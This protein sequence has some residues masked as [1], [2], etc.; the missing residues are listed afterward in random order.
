[1]ETL[2]FV[3]LMS[4]PVLWLGILLIPKSYVSH[5]SLLIGRA[6]LAGTWLTISGAVV[7]A[8]MWISSGPTVLPGDGITI[9]FLDGLSV[10]MSLLIGFIGWVIVRFSQTYLAGEK[11]YGA[12]FQWMGG[13]LASVSVLVISGN[14]LVLLAAWIA[15]SI[16]LHKLLIFYPHREASQLSARKKY[17]FSRLADVSLILAAGLIFI[18]FGTLEIPQILQQSREL[19]GSVIPGTL[20]LA[21]ACIAFGAILKSA[22]FPFH[23]WLPDTLETPTPVSALMHAG[24]ISA[25]GFLLI[26]LSPLVSLS[27]GL[28]LAL[29]LIGALTALFGSLVMLTQT[30]IKKSL[31]FS[32]VAQMGYMIMQCG[33]GAF[34]LAALHLVA[35][36]LYKAHAFLNSGANVPQKAPKPLSQLPWHPLRS[37]IGFSVA[38]ILGTAI[39]IGTGLTFG[40]SPAK[41]P[42]VFVLGSILIM[43][44]TTLLWTAQKAGKRVFL[45]SLLASIGVC[46]AYFALHHAAGFLLKDSLPTTISTASPWTGIVYGTVVAAFFIVC[47]LQISLPALNRS[48]V[49]QRI[50]VLIFNRFYVNAF[51]NRLLMNLWPLKKA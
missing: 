23:S 7:S 3:L 25:G 18:N 8:G 26:R 39:C 35:H 31:A 44:V 12:F 22:Q 14:L 46:V 29:V 10:I 37:I 50:Y 42:G 36:S 19:A 21:I 4:A 49:G 17:V 48:S 27:A 47:L 33:L 1:M 38:L 15:C 34:G 45:S 9:F 6:V 30:S 20:T 13:T 2:S 16:C 5:H 51:V 41:E 28:L 32:T 40:I 24:I 43:A 11:N